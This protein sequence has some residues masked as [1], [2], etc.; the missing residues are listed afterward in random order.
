MELQENMGVM[1]TWT[2][3][4]EYTARTKFQRAP[5]QTGQEMVTD[6]MGVVWKNAALGPSWPPFLVHVIL[7]FADSGYSLPKG[8]PLALT[9][10]PS[11]AGTGRLCF[12]SS[13][14]Q[15][16]RHQL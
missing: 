4:W 9:T 14:L 8:V 13:V 3:A 6:W 12:T 10:Y 1:P 2:I 7:S 11:S 5:K 16:A 15:I